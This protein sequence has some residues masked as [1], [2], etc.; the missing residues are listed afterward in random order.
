MAAGTCGTICSS[1]NRLEPSFPIAS[2]R[3]ASRAW[4]RHHVRRCLVG[5]SARSTSI[6]P[7]Q[8]QPRTAMTKAA[9]IIKNVPTI[10]ASI[11]LSAA[12]R[13][14]RRCLQLL[15]P[16]FGVGGN[17][18]VLP[19]LAAGASAPDAS[20]MPRTASAARIVFFIVRSPSCALSAAEGCI[21]DFVPVGLCGRL[22]S[23]GSAGSTVPQMYRR[24]S[25]S[26]HSAG[27]L[28]PGPWGGAIA[29]RCCAR[30]PATRKRHTTSRNRLQARS[31]RLHARRSG[32]C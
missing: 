27:A 18:Y 15:L 31:S 11:G 17:K 13:G 32:A 12:D 6:G 28:F 8:A 10:T 3:P 5:P 26:M 22:A 16:A 20:E 2:R 7:T 21:A 23:A 1:S 25:E 9:R 19:A 24:R 14:R 29:P 30:S 4:R